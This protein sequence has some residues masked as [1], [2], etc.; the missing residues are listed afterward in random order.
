VAS[1]TRG[2]NIGRKGFTPAELAFLWQAKDLSEE[3]VKAL[4]TLLD[5]DNPSFAPDRKWPYRYR[6]RSAAVVPALC[7]AVGKLGFDTIKV[8]SA[9]IAHLPDNLVAIIG[10]WDAPFPWDHGKEKER[11]HLSRSWDFQ[12][13]QE[14]PWFYKHRIHRSRLCKPSSR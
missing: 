3:T 11:L 14:A 5:Q 4:R 13:R 10:E 2:D 12:G 1:G 6:A 8:G 7:F 9:D